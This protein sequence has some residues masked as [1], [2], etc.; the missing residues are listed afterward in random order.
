MIPK[1]KQAVKNTVPARKR[2]Q[3]GKIQRNI[4]Q[5]GAPLKMKRS[6]SGDRQKSKFVKE[7]LVGVSV[8]NKKSLLI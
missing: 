8:S 5:E 6:L 3:N 7:G 1:N 2:K 4:A